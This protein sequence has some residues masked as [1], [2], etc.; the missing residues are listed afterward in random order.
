MLNGLVR[1][2]LVGHRAPGLDPGGTAHARSTL[3][4]GAQYHIQHEQ[5]HA[6]PSSKVNLKN[7]ISIKYMISYRLN[8]L[9]KNQRPL[10][11]IPLRLSRKFG[12][13]AV[14]RLFED[15]QREFG[16]LQNR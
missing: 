16:L 5:P 13:D 1:P 10:S 12:H 15:W 11:T 7:L 4:D 9:I 6:N 14:M 2:A 3:E 8:F